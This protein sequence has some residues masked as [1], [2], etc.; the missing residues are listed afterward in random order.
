M[1]K[2]L[3]ETYRQCRDADHTLAEEITPCHDYVVFAK[4]HR[5]WG[6]EAGWVTRIVYPSHTWPDK[7]WFLILTLVKSQHL[8]FDFI[9]YNIM[10]Y[11]RFKTRIWL[12][13]RYPLFVVISGR[14]GGDEQRQVTQWQ[15]QVFIGVQLL[16]IWWQ[17]PAFMSWH[18][19]VPKYVYSY[20]YM[21]L[22]KNITF[23]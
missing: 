19:L 17:I 20:V 1:R 5:G 9:N 14:A 21:V 8:A 12:R 18:I 4:S 23:K 6:S 10:I 3:C 16:N 15:Q 2:K 11:C 13:L 22:F 7:T